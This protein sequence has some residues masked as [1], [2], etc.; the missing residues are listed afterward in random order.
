MWYKEGAK[1][2]DEVLSLTVEAR[3]N[4]IVSGLEN[5]RR[6]NSEKALDKIEECYKEVL[7]KYTAGV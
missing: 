3:E 2:L 7:K 4:L 1:I 6:F 5:S